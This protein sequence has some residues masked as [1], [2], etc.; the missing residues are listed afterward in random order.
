MQSLIR[1]V[2]YLTIPVSDVQRAFDW[3]S[4]ILGFR[5]EF[6]NV[7]DGIARVDLED[8]PFLI[9]CKADA[10]SNCNFMT[11]S[12]SQQVI[13]FTSPRIDELYDYMKLNEVKTSE[14]NSDEWSRFFN[15]YDL[16]DNMFLVHS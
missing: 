12:Q 14:V 5:Q 8:G 7:E 13:T 3:Y 16:D 6:I 10:G 1:K 2:H 4:N 15:F 9:L 11:N